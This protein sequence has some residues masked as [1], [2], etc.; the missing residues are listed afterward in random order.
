MGDCESQFVTKRDFY[1]PECDYG[2]ANRQIEGKSRPPWKPDGVNL[3]L[4]LSILDRQYTFEV[5]NSHA[6]ATAIVHHDAE[7]TTTLG[8]NHHR[9]TAHATCT[10]KTVLKKICFT[11]LDHVIGNRNGF[12]T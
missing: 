1:K 3:I 4:V 6:G 5:L 7:L 11:V 10:T 2:H 8:V 12:L 9:N